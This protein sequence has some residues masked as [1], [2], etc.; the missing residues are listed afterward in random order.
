[1]LFQFPQK[2]SIPLEKEDQDAQISK[3]QPKLM[4]RINDGISKKDVRNVDQEVNR[5][6]E[7]N[8]FN[9]YFF[10][11]FVCWYQ[12]MNQLYNTNNNHKS[13]IHHL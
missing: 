9:H 4:T 5:Q 1:M 3:D 13:K 6:K 8:S 7:R 10:F 2:S 12:W 11:F